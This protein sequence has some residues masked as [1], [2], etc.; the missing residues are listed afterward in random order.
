LNDVL[1]ITISMRL[2][3]KEKLNHLLLSNALIDEDDYN[4]NI[5]KLGTLAKNI[6]KEV[7]PRFKFEI[8]L[9]F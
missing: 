1:N 6:K 9:F 4:L 5:N 8:D 7:N 3:L 2:K